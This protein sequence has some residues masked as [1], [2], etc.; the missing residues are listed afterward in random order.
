M[1][2]NNSKFIK[3]VK[4]KGKPQKY[5]FLMPHNHRKTIESKQSLTKTYG[6][7]S[8][9]TTPEDRSVGASFPKM[10]SLKIK[11]KN[12]NINLCTGKSTMQRPTHRSSYVCKKEITD[13]LS[14]ST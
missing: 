2:K 4:G 8:A 1:R 3:L 7:G 9:R 13:L 10:C 14:Q 6:E 12:L 11:N 5:T